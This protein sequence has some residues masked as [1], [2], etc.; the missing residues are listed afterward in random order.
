MYRAFTGCLSFSKLRR[1]TRRTMAASGLALALAFATFSIALAAN[2]QPARSGPV[3]GEPVS[4]GAPRADTITAGSDSMIVIISGPNE[5]TITAAKKAGAQDGDAG[6]G[7][8]FPNPAL[9]LLAAMVGVGLRLMM[10]L[11][12][13]VS[14]K[15]RRAAVLARADRADRD[16]RARGHSQ[17]D[18][19]TGSSDSACPDSHTKWRN[20]IETL[21]PASRDTGGNQA[22]IAY[23]QND[24]AVSRMHGIV[25]ERLVMLAGRRNRP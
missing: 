11:R 9:A 16:G 10:L 15:L 2:R 6:L 7:S 8:A 19:C 22:E 24:N 1:H 17:C 4:V 3:S 14:P 13:L 12:R 21:T 20:R 5:I 23:N 18:C 25:V